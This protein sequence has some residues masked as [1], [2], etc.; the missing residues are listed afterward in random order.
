M[1]MTRGH[2]HNGGSMA[3]KLISLRYAGTRSVCALE[4][5]VGTKAWWDSQAR[6]ITCV[7]CKPTVAGGTIQ[8]TTPVPGTCQWHPAGSRGVGGLRPR[9]SRSQDAAD[10]HSLLTGMGDHNGLRVMRIPHKGQR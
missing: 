10:P 9:R 3:A 1:A 5:P 6:T 8:A 7:G 4:L 2:G